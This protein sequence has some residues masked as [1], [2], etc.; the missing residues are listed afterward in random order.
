MHCKCVNTKDTDHMIFWN[1]YQSL[2]ITAFKHLLITPFLPAGGITKPEVGPRTCLP[3]DPVRQCA[4]AL[5]HALSSVLLSP[6]EKSEGMNQLLP[7]DGQALAPELLWRL[8]TTLRL[9]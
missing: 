7:Q 8:E 2:L 4:V 5:Y 6:V 9:L 3:K 1:K